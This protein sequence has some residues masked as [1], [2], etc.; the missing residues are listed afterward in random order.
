MR[1][2]ARDAGDQEHLLDCIVPRVILFLRKVRRM[3]LK[4]EMP[5][6]SGAGI[7][8][9]TGEHNGTVEI[10]RQEGADVQRERFI[11]RGEF[12]PAPECH[13]ERRKKCAETRVALAFPRNGV[14]FRVLVVTMRRTLGLLYFLCMDRAAQLCCV[15]AQLCCCDP[16]C[17][18]EVH[19][20]TT[21]A[22]H[23]VVVKKKTCLAVVMRL[24]LR[25][26]PLQRP[27]LSVPAFSRALH[28]PP[29]TAPEAPMRDRHPRRGPPGRPERK[30]LPAGPLPLAADPAGRLNSRGRKERRAGKGRRRRKAGVGR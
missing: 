13:E 15:P 4:F 14:R 3:H 12:F 2:P 16:L 5:S 28:L 21:L 23:L 7:L 22:C 1:L 29:A 30:C 9:R 20:G 11:A 19:W 17:V 26:L 8:E 18:A 24:D 25:T 10:L 27:R 6:R